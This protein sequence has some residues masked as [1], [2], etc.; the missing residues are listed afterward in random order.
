MIKFI[1]NCTIII[2]VLLGL[3][4]STSPQANEYRKIQMETTKFGMQVVLTAQ[5]GMGGELAVIMLKASELVTSSEQ[6]L[7]Y[8]VQISTSDA[9]KI[10][11]TEVWESQQAHQ[12]SLAN[13][14]VLAL[15]GK[16]KPLISDM[17]HQLGT[18]LN[19]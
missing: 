3:L 19:I 5:Q 8:L 12:A 2:I 17:S 6:C 13:S 7:L 1:L 18:P 10:L 9:D 16:A 4:F 11:I 15:I 14:E